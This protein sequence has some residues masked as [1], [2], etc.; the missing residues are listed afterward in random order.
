MS[1][2]EICLRVVPSPVDI[3][4]MQNIFLGCDALASKVQQKPSCND[5]RTSGNSDSLKTSRAHELRKD[6]GAEPYFAGAEVSDQR[7]NRQSLTHPAYLE[8]TPQGA[9]SGLADHRSNGQS[10]SHSTNLEHTP[11]NWATSTEF[12]G[13]SP[14]AQ[15]QPSFSKDEDACSGPVEGP[16]DTLL[17]KDKS[18]STFALSLPKPPK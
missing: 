16:R 18:S 8:S 15:F 2:A 14:K 7:R 17:A 5:E 11:Q 12:V 1:L 3:P 9:L 10:F 6:N 13:P 4:K